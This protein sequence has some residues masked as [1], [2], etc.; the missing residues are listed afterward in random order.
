[1]GSLTVISIQKCTS[2]VSSLSGTAVNSHRLDRLSKS[3]DWIVFVSTIQLSGSTWT[4]ETKS[5]V[6]MGGN[7]TVRVASNKFGLWLRII[8]EW[9]QSG[10]NSE[11]RSTSWMI[12]RRWRGEVLIILRCVWRLV[13][14]WSNRD[15]R[16]PPA[17]FMVFWLAILLLLSEVMMLLWMWNKL[18]HGEWVRPATNE[19]VGQLFSWSAFGTDRQAVVIRIRTFSEIRPVLFCS[20]RCG[21]NE[22]NELFTLK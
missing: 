1:M 19:M 9:E 11:Y 6:K 8:L 21:V 4:R 10:R 13:T 2:T 12:W 7:P 16:R 20:L 22:V 18:G 15:L 14:G 5:S 17:P 3:F